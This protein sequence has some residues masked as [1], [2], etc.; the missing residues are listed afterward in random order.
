MWGWI[1]RAYDSVAGK[2]DDTVR[3]WVHDLIN[4]VYGFIHTVFHYVAAA[5]VTLWH[6]VYDTVIHVARFMQQAEGAIWDL[7]FH[8]LPHIVRWAWHEILVGVAFTRAVWHWTAVEFDRLRH[9]IAHWLDDLRRWVIQDIW[10]PIWR[11]LGP[12][13]HW[14][15]HEGDTL[16]HYLT[17]PAELVDLLWDYLLAKMER[18]AWRA[19]K[20]L[21]RFFLALIVHNMR[22]FALLLEDIL[23]AIL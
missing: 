20:I 1:R 19:G 5:W 22:T 23:N 4:G 6:D 8:I 14:I 7:W 9:D 16:W 2:I 3:H 12:A 21:G 18:E 10:A 17:H 13:W 15:T 11:T